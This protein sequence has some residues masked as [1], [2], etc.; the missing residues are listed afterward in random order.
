MWAH[1]IHEEGAGEGGGERQNWQL[2]SQ[3][4]GAQSS[5]GYFGS[6]RGGLAGDRG[7]HLPAHSPVALGPFPQ[8]ITV[9]S[10]AQA[11]QVLRSPPPWA[12]SHPFFH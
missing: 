5:G 8:R 12:L 3:Q 7:P 6:L 2:P 10:P 9:I 11:P 1:L 4:R